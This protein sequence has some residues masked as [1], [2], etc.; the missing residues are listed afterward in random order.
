MPINPADQA[1]VGSTHGRPNYEFVRPT[2]RTRSCSTNWSALHF[3]RRPED[4]AHI[5]NIHSQLEREGC[6]VKRMALNGRLAAPHASIIVQSRTLAE[7]RG[8]L[9]AAVTD[10]ASVGPS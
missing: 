3:N 7:A 1:L 4:E 10:G 5:S 8:K 9:W 2:L 6:R